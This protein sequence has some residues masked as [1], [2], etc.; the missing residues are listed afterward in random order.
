MPVFLICILSFL[1]LT[2]GCTMITETVKGV[3]GV[4]TKSLEENRKEALKK[5]FNCDYNSCYNK[6]R[7]ILTNIGTYIYSQSKKRQMIA[8]YVSQEDT[9]AVGIFFKSIDANNIQVE[10]SSPST[11]AKEF[12][13]GKLFSGLEKSL[14]LEDEK[15]QAD[16]KQETGNK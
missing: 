4:S 10:V 9:T 6:A 2:S 1:L 16:A 7:K 8:V 15:G 13:A 12:I 11:Y 3:A 14:N 5:T